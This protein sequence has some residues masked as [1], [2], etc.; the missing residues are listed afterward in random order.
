MIRLKS[1]LSL[2]GLQDSFPADRRHSKG[3]SNPLESVKNLR[4]KLLMQNMFQHKRKKKK[5]KYHV[6]GNLDPG[7]N[8]Y[9]NDYMQMGAANQQPAS[10][11]L[12]LAEEKE[13][14][15]QLSGNVSL[16]AYV[17]EE[18]NLKI[19]TFKKRKKHKKSK[20]RKY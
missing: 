14:Y 20:K 5:G 7:E 13:C 19:L 11:A 12:S 10:P 17:Q 16:S 1:Y 4:K 2:P 15:M 8:I 6:D 18:D 9:L 3:S